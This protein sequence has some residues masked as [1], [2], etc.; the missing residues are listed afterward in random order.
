MTLQILPKR[1]ILIRGGIILESYNNKTTHWSN[2]ILMILCESFIRK[3]LKAVTLVCGAQLFDKVISLLV[4]IPTSTTR[5][6]EYKAS[7]AGKQK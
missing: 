1:L 3:A 7:N 2:P 4:E 6:Q 5:R